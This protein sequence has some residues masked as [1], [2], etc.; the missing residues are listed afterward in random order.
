MND[1][2]ENQEASQKRISKYL[3]VIGVAKRSKQ[4]MREAKE[5]G[6]RPNQV[7]VVR[8]K[9]IKPT[10]IALEEVRAG[11]VV[12]IRLEEKEIEIIEKTDDDLVLPD[13]VDELIK[14]NDTSSVQNN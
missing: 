6:L 12:F 13:E 7:A 5:R 3:M 9:H 10:T 4:L 14:V 8:S 1:S 11:K 2:L